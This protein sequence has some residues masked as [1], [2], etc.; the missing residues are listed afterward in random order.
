MGTNPQEPVHAVALTC[1]G[2]AGVQQRAASGLARDQ[3]GVDGDSAAEGA[4]R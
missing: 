1:L 2:L 3:V 4:S